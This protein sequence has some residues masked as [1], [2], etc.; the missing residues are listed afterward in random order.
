MSI[1]RIFVCN[2]EVK[3]RVCPF[4]RIKTGIFTT[5]RAQIQTISLPSKV[6]VE[7]PCAMCIILYKKTETIVIR[8]IFIIIIQDVPENNGQ[9]YGI[10]HVILRVKE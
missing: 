2:G 10:L 4:I 3:D 9:L 5:S 7:V 6:N 8:R 1:P